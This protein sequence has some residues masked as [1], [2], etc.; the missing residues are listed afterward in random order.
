MF[1]KI[2][3]WLLVRKMPVFKITQQEADV[4]REVLC[5]PSGSVFL[6]WRLLRHSEQ[7]ETRTLVEK[8]GASLNGCTLDSHLDT[9]GTSWVL[10]SNRW[11]L[12]DLWMEKLLKENGYEI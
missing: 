10:C 9:H 4:L 3:K 1:F 5:N 8:I 7:S 11:L 6:C 2:R 12:R